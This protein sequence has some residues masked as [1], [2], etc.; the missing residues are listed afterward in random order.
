MESSGKT[1]ASPRGQSQFL[2]DTKIGTVPNFLPFQIDDR[3][4]A[5]EVP[6]AQGTETGELR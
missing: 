6:V 4:I 5:P 3:S 1:M 2:F